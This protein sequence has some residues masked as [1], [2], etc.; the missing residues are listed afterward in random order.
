[1]EEVAVVTDPLEAR[2]LVPEP[3]QAMRVGL[4]VPLS[5]TLGMVGPCAVNCARLAAA[6]TNAAGGLLGQ[7]VELVLVDGGRGPAAVAAEVA[8]L[9]RAGAV[10]GLVGTHASDVRVEVVRAIRGAVPYVY[11][12]PYEGGETAPG[13]YLVGETPDRQL[14]PVLDWLVHHRRARRWA[15]VGNDYVWP[16]RVHRAAR[17]Y[18]RTAHASVVAETYVPL[19][20]ADPQPLLDVVARTR[21]DAVLL[22]L[23]GGDLVTFN[24]AFASTRLGER[25]LRLCAALE[26][27]GL[28][29]AGGDTSG[30][31]Y[32]AMGYFGSVATDDG[33]AFCERYTKRYGW[34]APVLNGHAEACYDGVRLLA[35]LAWRAGSLATPRMDAV[36]DGTSIVGGRGRL[37]LRHRHVDHPVYL[38]R[39]DGLDFDVLR[40]F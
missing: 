12:P 19:G 7:P 23:V 21:A 14:R 4:V 34:Q 8:G 27:N 10:Q 36:A 28:L 33:L 35:A 39:A 18:L 5:G 40:S 25:V 30:E 22:T 9:V 20:L 37:T 26:E 1:V 13:V 31:L 32:A 6:E 11:T 29:G 38:A 17:R 24:R 3:G 2:L 15:L 16:R